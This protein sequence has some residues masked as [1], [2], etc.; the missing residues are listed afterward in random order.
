M[1]RPRV[2]FP[3]FVLLLA[4]GMRLA[5]TPFPAAP[6]GALLF[7]EVKP[8]SHGAAGEVYDVRVLSEPNTSVLVSGDFDYY[9]VVNDDASCG[10]SDDSPL[11]VSATVLQT[12]GVKAKEMGTAM[13]AAYKR[14]RTDVGQLAAQG[15]VQP[16]EGALLRAQAYGDVRA[17]CAAA[18][19]QGASCEPT[20]YPPALLGVFDTWPPP[21]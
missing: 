19:G 5:D 21:I 4:V 7:V 16:D 9:R 17:A 1:R 6:A 20:A 12:V 10:R 15:S 18:E 8:G 14:I 13:A 3:F 11:T 2:L